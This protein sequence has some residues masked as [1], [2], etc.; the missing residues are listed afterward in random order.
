MGRVGCRAEAQ[1]GKASGSKVMENEDWTFH[2]RVS[3]MKDK[4]ARHRALFPILG[5]T[6][7][8]G[9]IIHRCGGVR[10][11]SFKIL[12]THWMLNSTCELYS[13]DASDTHLLNC[14]NH[15]VPRHCQMSPGIQSQPR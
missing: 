2:I 10:F 1:E 3:D 4:K 8:W 11:G 5:T 6:D 12:S 15:D 14:E 13:I 9:L 7:S